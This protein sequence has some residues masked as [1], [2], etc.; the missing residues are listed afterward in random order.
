MSTRVARGSLSGRW[1]P[2]GD[3]APNLTGAITIKRDLPAGTKL[4]PGA[5]TRSAAGSDEFLSMVAKV[6]NSSPRTGRGRRRPAREVANEPEARFSDP[7]PVSA[8][9]RPA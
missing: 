4:W 2:R 1:S 9:G 5:W 6:A 3:G 7:P 8:A